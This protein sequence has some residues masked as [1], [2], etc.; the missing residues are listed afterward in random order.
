M[1]LSWHILWKCALI[2]GA[3]VL[4][5]RFSG[6]RSISQ[7]TAA[8][9]VIMISIGS[10]LANGVLE[11]AVWRSIATAGLFLLFLVAI[12]WL[13]YRFKLAERFVAGKSVI[14]VRDGSVD[15]RS[16]KKLRLPR[17]QLE[18]RLRQKGIANVSDLKIATIE[19][20]GR[21]GYELMP[22]AKPATAEQFDR[23]LA[24]LERAGLSVRD[25]TG[26]GRPGAGSRP[27]EEPQ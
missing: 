14:V 7:M 17:S 12:E 19:V 3:G 20:N 25:D 24:S 4:M 27:A 15:E 6:R 21:L 1:D 11:K 23:L 9:T 2:V 8:T 18:M 16:L 13:E 5:L 22:H 26:A 10:L